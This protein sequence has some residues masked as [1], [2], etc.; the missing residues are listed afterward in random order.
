MEEKSRKS[1]VALSFVSYTWNF[2]YRAEYVRKVLGD[3]VFHV[4]DV[5]I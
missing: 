5:T 1:K 3:T 2:R 4:H